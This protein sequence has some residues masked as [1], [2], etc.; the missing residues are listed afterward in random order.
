MNNNIILLSDSYKV[1]HWPQYP[2]KTK[3]IRSY[4]ESRGGLWDDVVFFGL[5][6]YLKEYLCGPVVTAAKIDEAEEY[7]GGHFSHPIFNKAGWEYILHEHGGCLPVSIKAQPEGLV[8]PGRNVMMTIE[9]TDGESAEWPAY[10]LTNYL[11]TLLVQVW[12]GSTVATQSREMKKIIAGYLETTGDPSL[13]DFKLH[14]FGFR[15]V[16]SVETAGVGGLAHLVN[17]KGTDTF[18][19]IRVGREYYNEPMAGFSIP[20]A[21]HSTITAWGR[22]NELDACRNMLTTYPEGLVAVVSDSY[23]IFA[24]CRDIWGGV[25]KDQVIERDGTLVVRPDSGHPPEIVVKVLDILGDRFGAPENAKGYRVLDDHVRVIQ[26]DGID[27]AMLPEILEAMERAGWSADNI[28]FGSGGGLLQKLNRDTL[29]FAFKCCSANVDGEERDVF[30]D[31]VTDQGKGSKRG[32]LILTQ[33]DDGAY[34]TIQDDGK[35]EDILEEVFR[36]GELLVDHTL[37]EVRERAAI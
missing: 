29:K 4:F 33:D 15:G 18:Q 23:D 36:D 17:F 21:E 16:S 19:G 6:Y 28:A 8:V 31:P 35:T 10:W 22:E 26:G 37:S 14:D 27:F 20:A 2:P 34:E 3:T 7:F 12:Y 1:S 13:V 32:Q 9:N 5:Q 25:L 30:K 11:E 24:A